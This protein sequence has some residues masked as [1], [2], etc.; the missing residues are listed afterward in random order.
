MKNSLH[1]QSGV[2]D[3]AF[4]ASG[5]G[6]QLRELQASGSAS[7]RAIAEYLLTVPPVFNEV[8]DE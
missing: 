5:L 3:V 8:D 1:Q 7:Q 2:G 6:L 4:A